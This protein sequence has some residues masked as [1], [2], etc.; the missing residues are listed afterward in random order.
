MHRVARLQRQL[1]AGSST[2]DIDTGTP[3]LLATVASDGVA[4]LTLNRPEARNAL[5][6]DMTPFLRAVLHRLR[7]DPTIK[8]LVITGAGGAFC[9]GGNMTGMDTSGI[10]PPAVPPAPD[11]WR[12]DPQDKHGEF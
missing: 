4:V 6:D 8:C 12:P 7:D 5:G 1:V 11:G 9:A 3:L 2:R 10:V